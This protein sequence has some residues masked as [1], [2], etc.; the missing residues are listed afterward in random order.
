VAA[1]AVEITPMKQL[2]RTP[3]LQLLVKQV[4]LDSRVLVVPVERAVTAVQHLVMAL[5]ARAG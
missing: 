3:L 5:A 1:A 2:F 4:E